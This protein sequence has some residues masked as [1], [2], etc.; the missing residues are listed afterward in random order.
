MES[1]EFSINTVPYP[2]KTGDV[3][4]LAGFTNEWML[5]YIKKDLKTSNSFYRGAQYSS[6]YF[7]GIAISTKNK[8]MIVPFVSTTTGALGGL[9]TKKVE[10]FKTKSEVYSVSNCKDCFKQEFIFNGK[11]DS[12]LKFIYREYIND[13]ARP[14]F[15]QEL[16]YD[17]NES[18]VIGFKGLRIEVVKATNTNIAYKILS[19]FNKER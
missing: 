9:Y 4:P 16:Q 12:N 18:N 19:S 15:N 11:I 6:N 17:S 3:L 8:D 13:M 10:G 2:Y 14:A 5:Y 1:P 7:F